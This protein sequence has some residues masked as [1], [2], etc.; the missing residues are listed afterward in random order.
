[1]PR[2]DDANLIRALNRS[3]AL[4]IDLAGFELQHPGDRLKLAL[5]DPSVYLQ[6]REAAAKEAR[7]L[8]EP[9]FSGFYASGEPASRIAVD[10]LQIAGK[11]TWDSIQKS[12]RYRLL[13]SSLKDVKT[14]F[15]KTPTGIVVNDHRTELIL[16]GSILTLGAGVAQYHFRTNDD[17][18]KLYAAT[19]SSATSKIKIGDLTF[20]ATFPTFVPSKRQVEV[21]AFAGYDFKVVDTKVEFGGNFQNSR[22]KQIDAAAAI[23]VPLKVSNLDLKLNAGAA[24]T[25]KQPEFGS[26]LDTNW[27]FSLGIDAGSKDFR[28]RAGV[29]VG[30]QNDQ[31]RM[32]AGL[33]CV[34]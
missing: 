25:F 21:K 17:L 14:E 22:M 8:I 20:G 6:I 15:D 19:I 13:E 30:K 34:F 18:A 11:A 5:D 24:V 26:Q 2:K 12:P 32:T 7:F 33:N 28:L 1:M 27:N 10:M 9:T 23:T 16:M 3:V 31:P 29:L 4:S